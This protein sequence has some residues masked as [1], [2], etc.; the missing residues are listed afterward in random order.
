M[1]YIVLYCIVMSCIVL[2]YIVLYCIVSYF[3]LLYC[4]VM[5]CIVLYCIAIDFRC[6]ASVD[7]SQLLPNW[8]PCLIKVYQHQPRAKTRV[9]FF[10][11]FPYHF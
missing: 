6:K 1:L 2:Y 4:V 3:I 11:S 10:F 8:I 9:V 5:S 7:A